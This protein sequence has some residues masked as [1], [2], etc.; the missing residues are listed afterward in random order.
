MFEIVFEI[1]AMIF[2]IVTVGVWVFILPQ[3]AIIYLNDSRDNREY[4]R[5][6]EREWIETHKRSN[7]YDKME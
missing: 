2:C 6:V 1:C 7:D 4:R 3:I 5:M